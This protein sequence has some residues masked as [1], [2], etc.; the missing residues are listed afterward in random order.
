[1]AVN[2]VAVRQTQINYLSNTTTIIVNRTYLFNCF[3][4][5]KERYFSVA[6]SFGGTF[7]SCHKKI[8]ILCAIISLI[9]G[10]KCIALVF[11]M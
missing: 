6:Y 11:H 5:L 8:S 10:L 4:Q 9:W 3:W 7:M 1:M 2:L